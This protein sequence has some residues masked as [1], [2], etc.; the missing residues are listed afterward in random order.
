MADGVL[1]WAKPGEQAHRG[2]LEGRVSERSWQSPGSGLAADIRELTPTILRDYERALNVQE[3]PLLRNPASHEQIME[4]ARQLVESL[5]D[6][7]SGQAS[8]SRQVAADIGSSRA[9]QGFHPGESLRAAATLF[10]V[11]L[12][13]VVARTGESSVRAQEMVMVALAMNGV[14][15]RALGAAADAYAEFQLDRIHNAHVEERRR[16]S[17]ELHDRIGPEV[18]VAYHNLLLYDV[19]RES[20]PLA[21]CSHVATAQ[22]AMRETLEGVRRVISDLRAAEPLDSLD[23]ALRHFLEAV[24]RPEV[25]VQIQVTGDEQWAP[26][27]TRDECFLILRE[28]VR[29]AFAHASPSN[30]LVRV[31]IT[32]GELRGV[33]RDDGVGFDPAA[34]TGAKAGI[35][36]M[37][38][39]ITLLNGT[40]SLD[41][42]PGRGT[43]IDFAIPL[44]PPQP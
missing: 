13:S 15:M 11:V 17:R 40:V 14:L 10:D 4:H 8:A 42:L 34:V 18:S 28:A 16:I 21:A 2:W 25:Q 7:L 29:N 31:R 12:R 32:P 41:S 22:E 44:P 43:T 5:I 30:V 38:E 9:A 26:P 36:S 35:A 39:R 6:E 27:D 1:I 33:V 3:S 19:Y 23:K 20:R 37:K 24:E